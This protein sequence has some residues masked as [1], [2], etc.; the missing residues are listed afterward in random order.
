[1][2]VGGDDCGFSLSAYCSVPHQPPVLYITHP[3]SPNQL[4]L[5]RVIPW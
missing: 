4:L 1:M 5:A 2:D 3:T